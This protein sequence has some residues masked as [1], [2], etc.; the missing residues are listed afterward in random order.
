MSGALSSSSILGTGDFYLDK[1]LHSIIKSSIGD[2]AEDNISTTSFAKVFNHYKEAWLISVA[3]G[4]KKNI[5]KKVELENL[6]KVASFTYISDSDQI[7]FLLAVG[8][9]EFEKDMLSTGTTKNVFDIFD[10]DKFKISQI[11]QEY[12]NAGFV[13]LIEMLSGNETKLENF[14]V[15]FLALNQDF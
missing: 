1:E 13:D 12:A 14:S 10:K 5:R 4:Y 6:Q 7:S 8:V 2:A 15:N 3:L 11:C 9:S